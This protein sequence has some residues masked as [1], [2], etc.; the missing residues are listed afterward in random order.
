MVTAEN[1]V[2]RLW[3]FG[4]SHAA[5]GGPALLKTVSCS[6]QPIRALFITPGGLHVVGVFEQDGVVLFGV[7]S[8]LTEQ[9]VLLQP[10]EEK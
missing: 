1:G 7:K 2:I 8:G 5:S 10:G 9:H 4:S 3:Y 6:R